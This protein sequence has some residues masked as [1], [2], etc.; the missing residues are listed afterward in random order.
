M[1]DKFIDGGRKT[2]IYIY[3]YIYIYMALEVS[4]EQDP[5]Q[6]I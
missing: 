4:G 2:M 6:P 5:L 1:S 3:I